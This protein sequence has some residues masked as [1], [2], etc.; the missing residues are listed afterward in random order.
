MATDKKV[1]Y[2]EAD[3]AE[4]IRLYE[5]GVPVAELARRFGKQERSIIGKLSR[6]NVYVTPSAKPKSRS[7]EG[8]TKGAMLN[9][10][11]ELWPE[12][13]VDGLKN[14]TKD[15]IQAITDLAEDF[16]DSFDEVAE[17]VSEAA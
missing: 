6:E 4:L 8:P 1:N 7:E 17:E 12:A 15:A 5:Q 16:A 14:A 10:L 13:P 3:T 2:T 11:K 9:R